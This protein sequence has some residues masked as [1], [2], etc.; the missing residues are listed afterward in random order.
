ML[1]VQRTALAVLAALTVVLATYFTLHALYGAGYVAVDVSD[2]DGH[3]PDDGSPEWHH[4]VQRAIPRRSTKAGAWAGAVCFVVVFRA[5]R[6]RAK[7][8]G[9]VHPASDGTP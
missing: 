9:P 7:S 1:M 5:L 8:P 4:A 3:G 2:G 6:P